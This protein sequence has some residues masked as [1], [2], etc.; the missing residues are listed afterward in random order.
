[1][2]EFFSWS[3]LATFAGASAATA[4]LTQFI[5]KP[6]KKIPTQLMSYIIS[7]V[8]LGLAT[9]ATET[10][11]TWRD[12]AIIPFNAALVSL[13]SN[14]SFEALKRIMDGKTK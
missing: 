2:N 12:W 5:K 1:M 9:A 7:I 14:G 13:S 11:E 6:L 4:L 3:M 10:F 8:V